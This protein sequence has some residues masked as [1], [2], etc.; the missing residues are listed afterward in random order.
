MALV[1]PFAGTLSLRPAAEMAVI[2]Q[3]VRGSLPF[4]G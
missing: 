4:L 2:Q 3:G 1:A